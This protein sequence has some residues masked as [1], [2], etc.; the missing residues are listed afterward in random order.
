MCPQ[1][2]PLTAL[3]DRYG[4][5]KAIRLFCIQLSEL[6][7]NCWVELR[8]RGIWEGK[9]SMRGIWERKL[10]MRGICERKLS[11]RRIWERKLSMRGIWVKKIHHAWNQGEE[12]APAWGLGEKTPIFLIN[13]SCNVGCVLCMMFPNI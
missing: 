7:T 12:T 11:M 13:N 2:G 10:R 1:A 4:T 8:M 5:L 3:L 9:L 6:A